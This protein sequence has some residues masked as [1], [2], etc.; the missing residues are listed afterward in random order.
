[1]LNADAIIFDFNGT[2]IQDE[3][4]NLDAWYETSKFF[5]GTPFNEEE[6][7]LING[8]PD[9]E[10]ALVI[11]KNASEE[12]LVKIANYKEELYKKLC[13]ERGVPFTRGA[14]AFLSL[15]K[16]PLAIASS[17]PK[18]NMAWYIPYFKL[19]RYFKVENIVAG[20]DDL[21]GKPE[22]DYFLEAARILNVDI[23]R[24]II[25]EDSTHGIE[26][27]KRAGCLYTIS[28]KENKDADLSIKDFDDNKLH[29]IFN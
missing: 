1:M 6:F 21:K 2:L 28:L 18:E 11:K 29:L 20:R 12:E 27:A 8:R 23:S 4:E 3:R 15:L 7:N 5:R 9:R 26:A 25:F 10:A 17:A 14:E 24:C 13:I 16:L 22:P 19:E